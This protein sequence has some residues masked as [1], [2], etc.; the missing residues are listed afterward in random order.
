MAGKR[1]IITLSEEERLWADSYSQAHKISVAEAI[2]QGLAILRQQEGLEAYQR[3]VEKTG[4]IWRQ[5]DGL[6]YQRAMRSEWE[7]S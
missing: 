3:L 1:I 7:E 5:G 4:G 2:R 6:T